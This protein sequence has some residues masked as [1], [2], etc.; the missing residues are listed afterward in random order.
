MP[1]DVTILNAISDVN[2]FFALDTSQ[3]RLAVIS[4]SRAKLGSGWI[5]AVDAWSPTIEEDLPKPVK[6]EKEVLARKYQKARGVLCP[7]ARSSPIKGP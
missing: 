2:R 3:P 7:D 5:H 1:V 6:T 4:H